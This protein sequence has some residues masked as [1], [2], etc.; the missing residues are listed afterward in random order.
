MSYDQASDYADVHLMLVDHSEFK[1]LPKPTGT[2]IDT[3][4]IW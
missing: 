2:L 3:R 4:G 1:C